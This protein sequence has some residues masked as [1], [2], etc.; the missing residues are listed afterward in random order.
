[1]TPS[2]CA[3]QVNSIGINT[4]S[5]LHVVDRADDIFDDQLRTTSLRSVIRAAK[6]GRDQGPIIFDAPLM[7]TVF[8]Q[9]K[10]V[11][12]F[13][14]GKTNDQKGGRLL[15]ARGDIDGRLLFGRIGI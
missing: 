8:V 1:M 5:F 14:P 3:K 9:V 13:T 2:G 6:I 10:A 11:A 4:G 12:V 7:D 15:N